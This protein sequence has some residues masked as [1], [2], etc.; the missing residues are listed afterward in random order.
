MSIV[1]TANAAV[2]ETPEQRRVAQRSR[3]LKS[4]KILTDDQRVIEC[5]LRDVSATGAKV[6]VDVSANLPNN[7]RLVVVADNS[8]RDAHIAWKRPDMM[9]VNFTSE[10]K[11][12][13]LRKL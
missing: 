4:G 10:A 1:E 13:T 2:A 7:F 3:V 8:I 9:G 5:T 11:P 12:C 6:I